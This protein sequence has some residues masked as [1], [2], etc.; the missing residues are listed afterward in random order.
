MAITIANERAQAPAGAGDRSLR[1]RDGA[2]RCLRDIGGTRTRTDTG[3]GNR[4]IL[5]NV[6]LC[7]Q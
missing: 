2:R 5:V 3:T 4:I 7:R 6:I 1:E